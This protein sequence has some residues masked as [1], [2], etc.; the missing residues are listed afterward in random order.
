MLS[1]IAPLILIGAESNAPQSGALFLAGVLLMLG[2]ALLRLNGFLIG[3]ETNIDGP[4]AGTISRPSPSC[5]SPPACSPRGSRL[6]HHHPP[7]PRAA[8][9]AGHRYI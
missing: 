8:R 9:E 6:H 4:A 1:F 7:F 5:W 2:G 3:Y